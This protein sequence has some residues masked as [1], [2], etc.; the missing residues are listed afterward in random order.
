MKN[1]LEPK[2]VV[3]W[4][5]IVGEPSRLWVKLWARL[6]TNKKGTSPATHEAASDKKY[7]DENDKTRK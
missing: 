3:N 4:R 2:I 1:K 6:V 5:P 7:E